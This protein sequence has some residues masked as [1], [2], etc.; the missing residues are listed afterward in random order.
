MDWISQS[1]RFLETFFCNARIWGRNPRIYLGFYSSPVLL[2]GFHRHSQKKRQPLLVYGQALEK[3][4]ER[5]RQ[6]LRKRKKAHIFHSAG[7][8][9]KIWERVRN[10]FFSS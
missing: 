3:Q 8:K 2:K 7:E 5:Q 6:H 10:L 4:R 9:K 1:F